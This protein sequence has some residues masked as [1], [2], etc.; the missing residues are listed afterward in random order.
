MQLDPAALAAGVRLVTLDAV[1]S[2]NAEA[3]TRA[4]TGERGP[5]WIT[6]QRQTGG[7]GRRGRAWVSEAG[8]LYATL[9]LTNPSPASKVAQLSFVSALAVHD[10]VADVAPMLGP[11]LT[12]K[13]PNDALCGG[14][15]FCG[16][17]L[18]GEGTGEATVAL[19]IGINC[20]HHPRDTAYPATD[21]AAAGA[22]VTPKA[23][24]QALSRAMLRRLAQWN[25]SDGFASTRV[26]WL[27]RAEGL[28]QPIQARLHDRELTG[29]FE[30]IDGGGQLVLR[31]S[32]GR[33]ETVAAG[34]VFPLHRSELA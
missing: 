24:F 28:G 15:K 33:P 3:L 12:L 29:I 27:K 11:R 30:T 22:H 32:D 25:N 26:D 13:W 8:N 9:L 6:A 1:G 4:R 34:D 23:V 2:T 17:L 31:R 7:R 5:L 10:A 21:L 18:E 19:G 14:K 20:T 16:I